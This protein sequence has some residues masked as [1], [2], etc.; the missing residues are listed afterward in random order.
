MALTAIITLALAPASRAS[1]VTLVL[2]GV[3]GVSRD[4]VYV[5]P[6]FGK[7]DSIPATVYCDDFT[8]ESYLNQPWQAT[9]STFA[10]LSHVRFQAGSA[11]Q[12]LQNYGAVAWLIEQTNTHP[13]DYADLSFALWAVFD[14]ALKSSSGFTANS[15][16]WLDEATSQTYTASEF[17][18]FVIYT[19][20]ETGSSSPQEMLA[21]APEPGSLALLV[22]GLLLLAG[23]ALRHRSSEA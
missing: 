15:Q 20:V 7:I 19:P 3:N 21:A 1:T 11:D 4:G 23:V 12:T 17:S 13:N 2:T 16:T 6:Y 14:P 18:D 8:H 5:D 10:D 9:T 22:L